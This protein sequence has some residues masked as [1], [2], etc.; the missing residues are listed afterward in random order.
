MAVLQ[1]RWIDTIA[2]PPDSTARRPVLVRASSSPRISTR[3][4]HGP[5]RSAAQAASSWRHSL[6]APTPSSRQQNAQ[7]NHRHHDGDFPRRG[8]PPCRRC[9]CRPPPRPPRPKRNLRDPRAR[10]A[11]QSRPRRSRPARSRPPRIHPAR[12]RRGCR[13]RGARE[14]IAPR[15]RCR[16]QGRTRWRLAA[17]GP[18]RGAR[19]RTVRAP[20]ASVSA[21]STAARRRRTGRRRTRRSCRAV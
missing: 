16:R 21:A 2:L 3:S 5:R 18:A 13:P 10:A 17:R 20:V 11:S 7:Q 9:R 1:S 8:H 14:R 4:C 15:R 19:G 6:L 12:S